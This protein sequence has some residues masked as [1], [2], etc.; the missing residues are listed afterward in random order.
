MAKYRVY[1]CASIEKDLAAIPKNDLRK[2][3]NRIRELVENPRPL[4]TEKL[5]DR[6]RG[7]HGP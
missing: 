3:L 6:E 4:G 1:F 2:M 7:N 5:T